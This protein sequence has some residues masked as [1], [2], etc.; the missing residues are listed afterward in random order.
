MTSLFLV[1]LV[2]FVSFNIELTK[3]NEELKKAN[4]GLE[5]DSIELAKIKEIANST[6]DLDSLYFDYNEQH[7]K[8]VLKVRSFFPENEYIITSL[9]NGCRDSLRNAGKEIKK[10]LDN[11]PKNKYLL[12]VE[13]QAS[14]NSESYSKHNYDLS[15]KRAYNLVKYWKN[16]CNIDFGQ[17]CEI[18]IAGSGDGVLNINSMRDKNNKLNQRFLIHVVPKNI[19]SEENEHYDKK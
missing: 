13:G 11:H 14:R 19:M 9:T 15:F 17:N 18:Q 6:K 2:L 8:F 4:E 16:D 5:T 10:F 7:E 12:L 3:K 1:M